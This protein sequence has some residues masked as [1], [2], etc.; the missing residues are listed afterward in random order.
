MEVENR[1]VKQAKSQEHRDLGPP[2]HRKEENGCL[3]QFKRPAARMPGQG[4]G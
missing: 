2:S 4:V 3:F 1:G